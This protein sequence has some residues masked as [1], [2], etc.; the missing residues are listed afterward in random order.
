MNKGLIGSVVDHAGFIRVKCQIRERCTGKTR[1]AQGQHQPVAVTVQPGAHTVIGDRRLVQRLSDKRLTRW[2]YGRTAHIKRDF[3]IG[4]F[5]DADIFTDEPGGECGD[6]QRSRRGVP[7][8]GHLKRQ[9]NLCGIAV[10]GQRSEIIAMRRRPDH[11]AR[12][13]AVR[14]RQLKMSRLS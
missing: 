14:Q 13:P 3:D 10:I 8:H 2:I 9:R 1:P 7:W 12:A 11:V 5:R 6:R 4:L